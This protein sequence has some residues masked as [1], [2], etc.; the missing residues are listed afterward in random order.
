MRALLALLALFVAWRVVDAQDDDDD[1]PNWVD[2]YANAKVESPELYEGLG[3][4]EESCGATGT[5]SK[6][7]TAAAVVAKPNPLDVVKLVVEAWGRKTHSSS[8]KHMSKVFFR[9]FFLVV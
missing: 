8:I 9:R 7:T 6:G 2:P 5:C 4:P 3:E 1:D